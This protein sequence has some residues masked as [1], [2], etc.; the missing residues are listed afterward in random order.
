MAGTCAA[1][2]KRLNHP[3]QAID[4]RTLDQHGHA[5]RQLR[6]QSASQGI[7]VRKPLGAGTESLDGA[8][9]LGTHRE[10]A[11]DPAFARVRTHVRMTVFGKPTELRHVAE[12]QPSRARQRTHDLEPGAHRTRI[13][14]VGVIDDPTVSH[15]GFELQAA[16]DRPKARE[17]KRDFPEG[18]AGGAGRCGG[19]QRIADVVRAARFER[20]RALPER[21][22]QREAR[23][24]FT[25]LDGLHGILRLEIRVR[26]HAEGEDAA[27][28]GHFEPIAGVDIVG[29]DDSRRGGVEAGHHFAFALGDAVQIAEAFEMFGAGVGDE[30]HGRPCQAH[31]LGDIADAIRAHFDHGTAMR[32]FKAH[33]RDGHA[34]MIIEIAV[35]R[36]AQTHARQN[37]GGHF[38]GGGLAVAAA[39][40][41]DGNGE[42]GAPGLAQLLQRAQ[43]VGN[44]DLRQRMGDRPFD[45]GADGAPARRRRNEVSAVEGGAAQRNEQRARLKRAAVRGH[46]PIGAIVAGQLAADHRGGVAQRS[47]HAAAPR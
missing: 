2:G 46:G 39:D 36:H 12:H 31:Q 29:V 19:G 17:A 35:S 7:G 4:A 38:L 33:Q 15:S 13:G 27:R 18:R 9:A 40:G 30:T 41:H 6:L 37:G 43:R 23:R 42:L 3:L 20:D 22:L 45:Q 14:V 21:T 16:C 32:V 28:R 25:A 47:L 44:R 5:R 34:D 10:Q 8:R 11:L 26:V 24:E 1:A